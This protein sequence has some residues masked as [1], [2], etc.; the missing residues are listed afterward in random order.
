MGPVV[1]ASGTE[2]HQRRRERSGHSP[3]SPIKSSLIRNA[4]DPDCSAT[5]ILS[6]A[7]ARVQLNRLNRFSVCPDEGHGGMVEEPEQASNRPFGFSDQIL[8]KKTEG[9]SVPVCVARSITAYTGSFV[10][11]ICSG[12]QPDDVTKQIGVRRLLPSHADSS[13]GGEKVGRK[14]LR[15]FAAIG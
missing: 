8:V 6:K 15:R 10:R 13:C 7:S 5:G 4:E 1:K 11:L 14:M 2:R 12:R 3:L 9:M